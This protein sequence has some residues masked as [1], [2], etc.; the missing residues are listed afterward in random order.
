MEMA[1]K[2]S[3]RST[4]TAATIIGQPATRPIARIASTTAPAS[5][6]GQTAPATAS[7]HS[8]RM[9]SP[10]IAPGMESATIPSSTKPTE[11]NAASH[12]RAP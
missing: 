1:W 12:F 3:P 2:L 9:S 6:N 5:T 11:L 10:R 7:P 8:V 4:P